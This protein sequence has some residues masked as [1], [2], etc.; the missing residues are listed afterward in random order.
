MAGKS[1]LQM[2]QLTMAGWEIHLDEGG[3]GTLH[4]L[5][6]ASGQV[7][8]LRLG[9][10]AVTLELGPLMRWDR[11]DEGLTPVTPVTPGSKS[12]KFQTMG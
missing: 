10:I 11:W 7:D 6:G 5:R 1:P 3:N 2:D 8:I 4:T 9:W 12:P